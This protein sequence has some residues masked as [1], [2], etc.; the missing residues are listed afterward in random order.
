MGEI[1]LQG[2]AYARGLEFQLLISYLLH[3]SALGCYILSEVG[4]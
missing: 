2:A 1:Q 4:R 3:F